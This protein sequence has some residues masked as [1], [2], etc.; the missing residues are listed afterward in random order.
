MDKV[1]VNIQYGGLAWNLTYNI[2][3]QIFSNMVFGMVTS[4]YQVVVAWKQLMIIAYRVRYIALMI[5][6]RRGGE[7]GEAYKTNSAGY[8]SLGQLGQLGQ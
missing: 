2:T 4:P 8:F 7:K 1:T 5:P 3:S 6:Q